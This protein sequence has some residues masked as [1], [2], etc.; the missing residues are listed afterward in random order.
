MGCDNLELAFN[1]SVHSA[2]DEFACRRLDSCLAILKCFQLSFPK[3]GD[4]SYS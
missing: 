1:A 2:K 3:I 4:V